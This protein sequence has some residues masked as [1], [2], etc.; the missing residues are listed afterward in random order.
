LFSKHLNFL[1]KNNLIWLF[2]VVQNFFFLK[3]HI[4]SPISRS[5]FMLVVSFKSTL[6]C[7]LSRVYSLVEFF[8]YSHGS[9]PYFKEYFVK[10]SQY[11]I[12][13]SRI[14][15][16]LKSNLCS[17]NILGYNKYIW[18]L[19]LYLRVMSLIL[20]I[21][22]TDL[23]HLARLIFFRTLHIEHTLKFCTKI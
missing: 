23:F 4:Y 14:K 13:F 15:G 16:L 17:N 11:S 20:Y 2:F 8:I 7:T 18:P 6:K 19:M 9:F 10:W 5:D 3:Y 22:Y 1:Q 21:L 12:L